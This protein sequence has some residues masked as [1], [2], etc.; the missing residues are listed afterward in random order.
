M[1]AEV[2]ELGPL[3]KTIHQID[4]HI[5]ISDLEKITKIYLQILLEMQSNLA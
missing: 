3:N 1:G 2:I 5:P 4:E